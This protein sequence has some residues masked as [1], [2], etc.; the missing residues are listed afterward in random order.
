MG[1]FDYAQDDRETH[2]ILRLHC[3]PLRMTG[4]NMSGRQG[5]GRMSSPKH[6]LFIYKKLNFAIK[7]LLYKKICGKLLSVIIFGSDI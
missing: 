2:G 1:S 6:K 5:M 4:K 7:L 3:V